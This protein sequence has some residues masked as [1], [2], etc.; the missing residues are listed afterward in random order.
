M[1]LTMSGKGHCHMMVPWLCSSS[2]TDAEDNHKTF[3]GKHQRADSMLNVKSAISRANIR[4]SRS[5]G[6]ANCSMRVEQIY[7]TAQGIAVGSSRS[8]MSAAMTSSR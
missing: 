7:S 8:F 3:D 5:L 1:D 2:M 6:T 4:P